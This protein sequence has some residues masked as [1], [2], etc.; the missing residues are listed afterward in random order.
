[1]KQEMISVASVM[2]GKI[3]KSS[4]DEQT[5]NKLFDETLREMGDE[6]WQS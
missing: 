1:M 6:T 2:A 5:Q 3:I 4:I